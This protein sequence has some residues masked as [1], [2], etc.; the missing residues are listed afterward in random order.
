MADFSE[1][2]IYTVVGQLLTREEFATLMEDEIDF[3][4]DALYEYSY[5]LQEEYGGLRA[6]TWQHGDVDSD[7]EERAFQYFIVG[8]VS[9]SELDKVLT[10]YPGWSKVI[11]DIQ[12]YTFYGPEE[13]DE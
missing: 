12:T 1:H 2:I 6:W 10:E 7:G 3:P 5:C 8:H 4:Q 11:Q 13:D 9:R